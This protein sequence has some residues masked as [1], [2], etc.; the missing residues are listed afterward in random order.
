MGDG[1]GGLGCSSVQG[2]RLVRFHAHCVPQ[3]EMIPHGQNGSLFE[4]HS[5][6]KGRVSTSSDFLVN[7]T[8]DQPLR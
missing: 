3:P 7:I 4:I 6:M 1:D 5:G 8:I 2:T